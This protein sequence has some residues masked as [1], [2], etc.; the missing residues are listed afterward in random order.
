[1]KYMLMIYGSDEAW[2][3]LSEDE[4]QSVYSEYYALSRDLRERGSYVDANELQDGET[5][6]TVRVRNGDA[7]TT[8]G[9]FS[10]TKERLGGYYLVDCESLDEAIEIAAR[11]PS[12]RTGAVEVRP[13]AE[14]DG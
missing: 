3:S 10:E 14:H 5:A 8:D 12:A 9:P 1:M 13:V 2:D 11:I 7:L 6:T 4:R